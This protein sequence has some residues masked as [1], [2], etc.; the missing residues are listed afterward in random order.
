MVNQEEMMARRILF[1]LLI[2]AAPVSVFAQNDI[3]IWINETEFK[4]TTISETDASIKLKF[5]PKIGYGATF[6][7]FSG[8]NMSTEFGWHQLKGDAK[9]QLSEAGGG[10]HAF[11]IGDFKTNQISAILKWHWMPRSYV[12]PYLGAG[13]AYYSGSHLR[14]IND[15]VTG[16]NGETVDFD[17]KFDY[18]ISG[19]LNFNVTRSIGIGLDLKY[20]PYKAHEKGT[21][22]SDDITL[23]PRTIALGVRFR[24]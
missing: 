4:S 17:S 7:H 11:D 19:G 2:L 13:L 18:V 3:G 16:T 6:N 20:A 22:S 23:D 8:P 5:D 14:T 15:P 24:M 10:S 9:A 1:A 12:V 21:D